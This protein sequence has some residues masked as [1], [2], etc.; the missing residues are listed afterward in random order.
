MI[1][2]KYLDKNWMTLTV[3]FFPF[4]AKAAIYTCKGPD[5]GFDDLMKLVKSVLDYIVTIT[6]P[7]SAIMF[8]YAGFLYM[9][10]QGSLDKRKKANQIFTNVGIGLFFVLAAWLIV[11]AIIVGLGAEDTS[12]LNLTE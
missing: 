10:S 3:F 8:A 4:F 5:C 2:K 6:V 9:T 11:K 7:L 12:Y 1:M